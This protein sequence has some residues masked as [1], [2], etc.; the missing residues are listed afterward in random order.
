MLTSYTSSEE[1]NIPYLRKFLQNIRNNNEGPQLLKVVRTSS[2]GSRPGQFFPPPHPPDWFLN[3]LEK[4]FL[5]PML[6]SFFTV[7]IQY[8]GELANKLTRAPLLG[9]A[10]SIYLLPRP[11]PWPR[12]KIFTTIS[13]T[14]GL[15]FYHKFVKITLDPFTMDMLSLLGFT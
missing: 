11:R 14:L 9:L 12:T 15:H 3:P 13:M 4:T 10:K 8:N 7:F 5:Q 6:K 1:E 2:P